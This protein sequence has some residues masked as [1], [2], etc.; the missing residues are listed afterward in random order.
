MIDADA[1]AIYAIDFIF[2][3]LIFSRFSFSFI[4]HYFMIIDID[5]FRHFVA[6]I[7]DIIF[8]FDMILYSAMPLLRFW[9]YYCHIDRLADIIFI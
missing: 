5:T 7:D 9:Y 1:I 6:F 8:I 2:D 3:W 4:F